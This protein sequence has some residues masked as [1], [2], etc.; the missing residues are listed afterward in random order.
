MAD[1]RLDDDTDMP[2]AMAMLAHAGCNPFAKRS[3]S[4][5]APP[6]VATTYIHIVDFRL[7]RIL[8][9]KGGIV[10]VVLC[11]YAQASANA[12]RGI[13]FMLFNYLTR[14]PSMPLAPSPPIAS[15]SPEHPK[16]ET[17]GLHRSSL[18]MDQ[19]T[20]ARYTYT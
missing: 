9:R 1:R 8:G 6:L 5:S 4:A 3:P 16:V 14:G 10:T 15:V 11:S 17:D 7:K 2:S 20:A 19:R 12:R 18:D 13:D